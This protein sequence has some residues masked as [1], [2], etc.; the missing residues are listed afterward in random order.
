M[1]RYAVVERG[2][3]SASLFTCAGDIA[4]CQ[5]EN[6]YDVLA[7]DKVTS[8]KVVAACTGKAA[9]GEGIDIP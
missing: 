9:I 4:Q 2:R 1:G 3:R 7:E 5:F 6:E 8:P